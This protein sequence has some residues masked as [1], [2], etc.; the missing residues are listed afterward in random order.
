MYLVL[1]CPANPSIKTRQHY[2]EQRNC[3]G[4]V[5]STRHPPALYDFDRESH[6]RSPINCILSDAERYDRDALLSNEQPRFLWFARRILHAH[7]RIKKS[8]GGVAANLQ[9]R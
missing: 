2:P 7:A 5:F 1:K 3:G 8:S 4:R 9:T 6:G